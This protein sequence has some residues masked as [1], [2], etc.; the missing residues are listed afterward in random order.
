M[1]VSAS[2]G[3]EALLRKGMRIDMK[4]KR[5]TEKIITGTFI[6]HAKG[7][8]FLREDAEDGN[9]KADYFVPEDMTNGAFHMDRVEAVLYRT[10]KE[11]VR[12]LKSQTYWNV[13]LQ[14][15]SVPL[16]VPKTSAL[17]CRIPLK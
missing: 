17:W 4:K 16:S 5:N 9:K 13:V 12:R 10:P 1:V 11:G 6:G 14:K 15:W 7:Y 3:G 2:A 8:G